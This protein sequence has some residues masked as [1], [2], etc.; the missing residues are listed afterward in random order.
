[1]TTPYRAAVEEALNAVLA[2]ET[3]SPRLREQAAY[4][5]RD[6][7]K[8]VRPCVLLACCELVGGSQQDALPF[9]VALELIHS[10]SLVHDDLPSM[11][12]DELRR[13]KPACHK[14]FGEAN[15]ILTGD[16]LL[17]LAFLLLNETEG[18]EKAKATLAREALNMVEGQLIDLNDSVC[19][20]DTLWTLYEKKT[21]ALFL[22]AVLCGAMVGGASE[23]SYKSLDG[24][25]H[26]LGRLFQLT[27]DIL[28]ADKDAKE[29]RPSCVSLLGLD[30]A[31]AL[32]RRLA[33]EAKQALA[34]FTGRAADYLTELTQGMAERTV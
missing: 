32:A 34:P 7:G 33:A 24:F 17:T 15:A 28:D 21:G 6:G 5:V 30:E 29:G 13:G 9:A 18:R 22:A 23:Q 26:I 19:D 3:L 14:R 2:R 20:M 16:G 1:M 11:D 10:Y 27:D 8:R 25:A 12:D 4:C 31:K